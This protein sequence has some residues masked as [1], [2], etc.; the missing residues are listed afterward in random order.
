MWTES[1]TRPPTTAIN[2]LSAENAIFT[3]PLWLFRQADPIVKLTE[4]RR[5]S[6]IPETDVAQRREAG[7][8]KGAGGGA[9]AVGREGDGDDPHVSLLGTADLGAFLAGPDVPQPRAAEPAPGQ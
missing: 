6:D 2:L 5:G 4:F 3:S 1:L 9:V 7:G 8:V